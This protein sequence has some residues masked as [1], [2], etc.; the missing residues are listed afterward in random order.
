MK[1]S[2]TLM[3]FVQNRYERLK[4]IRD[5]PRAVAGGVAVGMFWG[6]TPLLG[7]KTLLSILFAWMFRCSKISAVI[8]V[9]LHDLLT[10]IWPIILRWEYDF[11][12]WILNHPH[13][14]SGETQREGCAYRVLAALQD[15]GDSLADIRGFALICGSLRSDF[16]LDCRKVAGAIPT[17]TSSALYRPTLKYRNGRIRNRHHC[18][19]ERSRASRT[20]ALNHHGLAWYSVR[21]TR[22][23]RAKSVFIMA[24]ISPAKPLSLTITTSSKFR[25]K[26]R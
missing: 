17:R 8:A 16:I 3:A 22:W 20:V 11:G 6:F 13:H 2:R 26:E 21:S 12:F 18:T 9:S 23:L 5:R 25:W 14:F 19:G 24:S 10:P 4:Q 7:L 1:L 15:V